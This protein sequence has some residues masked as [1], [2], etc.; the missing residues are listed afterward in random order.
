MK[1]QQKKNKERC[2]NSREEKIHDRRSQEET[3]KEKLEFQ[4][5]ESKKHKRDPRQNP[6]AGNE[7]SM[8]KEEES[9]EKST[10]KKYKITETKKK[11]RKNSKNETSQL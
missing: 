6:G 9:N 8:K 5:P 11:T 1:S 4:E 10:G 2:T 7:I 3:C